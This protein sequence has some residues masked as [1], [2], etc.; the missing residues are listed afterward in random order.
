MESKLIKV[1]K[2]IGITFAIYVVMACASMTVNTSEDID[3]LYALIVLQSIVFPFVLP[4]F[5]MKRH[6]DNKSIRKVLT[7][8]VQWFTYT[9]SFSFLIFGEAAVVVGY[10]EADKEIASIAAFMAFGFI[11]LG[12]LFIYLTY[13]SQP[14]YYRDDNK[15]V[16]TVA[17]PKPVQTTIKSKPIETPKPVQTTN[18]QKVNKETTPLSKPIIKHCEGCNAPI[19]FTKSGIQECEYCGRKIEY[20][21]IKVVQKPVQRTGEKPKVKSYKNEYR[22]NKGTSVLDGIGAIFSFFDALFNALA[23]LIG[24]VT[25]LFSLPFIFSDSWERTQRRKNKRY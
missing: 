8:I 14:F 23:P 20:K 25:A 19:T 3:S 6:K 17:K 12:V 24:F 11:I 1:L 13:D 2:I 22:G 5:S 4:I 21:E 15:K 16:T 9:F 10:T 7:Y 18:I